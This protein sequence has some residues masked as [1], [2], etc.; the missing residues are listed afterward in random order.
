MSRFRIAVPSIDTRNAYEVTNVWSA[1]RRARSIRKLAACAVSAVIAF[2]SGIARASTSI[3]FLGFR[4]G[5]PD[6]FVMDSDGSNLKRLTDV[7]GYDGGTFFSPDGT[8]I[9]WRRFFEDGARAEIMTMKT[10]GSDVRQLTRMGAVSWAPVYQPSGQSV[11]F[12]PNRP[13]L[14]NV[15]LYL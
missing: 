6:L 14:S 9:C 4:D 7:P 11:V 2:Q 1:P 8:R 15:E 3:V 5:N 10:E 12:A 13:G